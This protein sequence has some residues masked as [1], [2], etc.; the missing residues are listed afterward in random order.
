MK[1]CKKCGQEK[2]NKSVCVNCKK[3]Y[4]KEFYLKKKNE[5][6]PKMKEY[7]KLNKEKINEYAKQWYSNSKEKRKEYYIK[8][9]QLN[10]EKINEYH[11]HYRITNT[12]YI[13]NYVKER[14]DTDPLFRLK[15]IMRSSMNRYVRGY[16]NNKTENMVGCSI[17]E[18]KLHLEKQFLPGMNWDNHK[19]NGWHVDHI[20]PLSSARNKEEAYKL[21]HYTNLQPLWAG[22]NWSKGKQNK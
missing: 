14:Y 6:L 18:L 17:K 10:K 19:I 16:K 20:I 2:E 8:H 13:K 22:D 5:I 15:H 1:L 21:C 11:K 7:Q 12:D 4:N 9:H 3:N